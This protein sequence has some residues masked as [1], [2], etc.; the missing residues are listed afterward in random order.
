MRTHKGKAKSVSLNATSE[1]QGLLKRKPILKT[2]SHR[3]DKS[4]LL[5]TA[6]VLLL[7]TVKQDRS[8]GEVNSNAILEEPFTLRLPRHCGLGSTYS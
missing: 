7:I 1:I 4:Q 5:K 6:A 2:Q 8:P 3:A